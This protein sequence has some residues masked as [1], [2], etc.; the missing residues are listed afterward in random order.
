VELTARASW[1]DLSS[2]SIDG[3]RMLT[4]TVG[5]AWTWNRWVRVLA[6]YVFAR[7][8]DRPRKGSAHIGQLRLE[9]V[10]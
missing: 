3:G 4:A 8:G 10:L 1:L 2:G 6:G 5:P 7:T 9:F